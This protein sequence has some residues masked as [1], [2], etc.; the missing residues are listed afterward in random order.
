M[1]LSLSA[2]VSGFG[3]MCQPPCD[4]STHDYVL[5]GTEMTCVARDPDPEKLLWYDMEAG[6][7]TVTSANETHV[8]FEIAVDSAVLFTNVPHRKVLNPTQAAQ[9]SNM[10]H[11][12]GKAV[13]LS[14]D[15]GGQINLY[16]GKGS[17]L[18]DGKGQLVGERLAGA[19]H[20][21]LAAPVEC[22]LDEVKSVDGASGVGFGECTFSGD[23]RLDITLEA[24]HAFAGAGV[25]IADETFNPAVFRGL[26]AAVHTKNGN[27]E[28]FTISQVNMTHVSGLTYFSTRLQ[29]WPTD[30]S[31]G[32]KLVDECSLFIDYI[33]SRT[34]SSITLLGPFVP[35]PTPSAFPTPGA[36]PFSPCTV[37]VPGPGVWTHT[38]CVPL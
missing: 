16:A 31:T 7:C 37:H 38:G 12:D 21:V 4:F 3:T 36:S 30:F 8:L 19:N 32:E 6:K 17:V 15:V 35:T 9:L 27:Y 23:G 18:T 22:V 1:F 24:L 11:Y 25:L 5:S 10:S 14:Y 2:F 26:N 33:V 29:T 34:A 20:G 13:M 28:V